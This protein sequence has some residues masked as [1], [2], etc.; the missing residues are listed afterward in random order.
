MSVTDLTES[1]PPE[2]RRAEGSAFVLS[3]LAAV[4]WGSNFEATRIVLHELPPWT[5]AAGRFVFAAFGILLWLRLA[6]G[7]GLQAL[8]RN[9]LAF[10]VLGVVG[11]AGFNAALF[12]GMQSSSP[13]TAAL[14]MGTSPLTTNLL[15]ALIGG[16]W[17]SRRALF[18]MAISLV[19]VA[20]T[21]GAFSGARFAS[22]DLLIFAGSLA[23]AFYTIGCRRWVRAASPLETSAW[24]MLAGAA[25]L[26]IA[27][28][29]LEDPLAIAAAASPTAWGATLWMA[30]V[31]SVLAYLFWQVGIAVRGPAATSVL[32]NLVP[33]SALLIA[34][35]F[36]RMPHPTQIAGVAVAIFGVLLA[37]G[38]LSLRPRAQ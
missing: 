32:F 2:I 8:R 10:L 26:L 18:G 28:F 3:A 1:P 31:G 9:A 16:H 12:L 38:R 20:L 37:S 36:G 17:P 23:W 5:A 11:V 7:P 30:L 27:A 25:A 29:T 21:V 19:G 13:V 24:T 34:A 14:I 33:V 15:E 35:A 22:G 6:E 4:F